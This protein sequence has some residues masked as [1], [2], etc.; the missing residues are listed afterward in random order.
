MHQ[1]PDQRRL[2]D[3]SAGGRQR[4]A[5]APGRISVSHQLRAWNETVRVSVVARVVLFIFIVSVI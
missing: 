5:G 1:R 3:G 2:F 4:F